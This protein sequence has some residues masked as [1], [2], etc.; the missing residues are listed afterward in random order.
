[1]RQDIASLNDYDT[2]LVNK[3]QLLLDATLGMIDVE[4]KHHQTADGRLGGGCAVDLGRQHVERGYGDKMGSQRA[5]SI[6]AG[7]AAG[8]ERVGMSG[9]WSFV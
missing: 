1:V 6:W 7:S 2:Y 9:V 3:L 4:Q 5:S 8:G